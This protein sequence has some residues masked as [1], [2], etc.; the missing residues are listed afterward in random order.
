MRIDKFALWAAAP[1][2]P[3]PMSSTQRVVEAIDRVAAAF[4]LVKKPAGSPGKT[5]FDVYRSLGAVRDALADSVHPSAGNTN[6]QLDKH[7]ASGP[8]SK[9]Q[10]YLDAHHPELGKAYAEQF[11][12]LRGAGGQADAERIARLVYLNALE[13]RLLNEVPGDTPI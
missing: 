10:A 9:V 11:E 5:A 8:V 6:R 1:A 4:M 3:A 12:H 7:K 2:V 13:S